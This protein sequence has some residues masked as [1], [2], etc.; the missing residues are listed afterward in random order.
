MDSS[1]VQVRRHRLEETLVVLVVA[2]LLGLGSAARFGSGWIASLVAAFLVLCV[3][4]SLLD[5]RWKI[6]PNAIVYPAFILFGGAVVALWAAGEDV[7]LASAAWGFIGYGGALF[8]LA[9]L[10]P[11]AMGMG[12]VKLAALTGLVL[13]ALGLGYVS[14]AAAAAIALGG[15][16]AIL[17]LLTGTGRKAKIPF[18]PYLAAGAIVSVFWSGAI[19]D[20]Y[21][22]RPG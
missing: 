15:L 18:G 4:L 19:L 13:G 9:L 7:G 12:D 21:L 3:M 17:L 14:V 11:G 16:A 2:P 10:W 5:L 1:A 22:R 20:W 8:L 6:I